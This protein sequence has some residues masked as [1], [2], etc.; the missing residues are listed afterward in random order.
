MSEFSNWALKA[1]EKK[2][3]SKHHCHASFPIRLLIML[4]SELQDACVA[5][6][7]FELET[8]AK[9][10]AFVPAEGRLESS[11]GNLI[12]FGC[13]GHEIFDAYYSD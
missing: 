3:S 6:C 12:Q 11:D 4:H 8:S 9:P 13:H 5:N 7:D 1:I 2:L 10:V